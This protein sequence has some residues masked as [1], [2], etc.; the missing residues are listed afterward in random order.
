MPVSM[1]LRQDHHRVLCVSPVSIAQPEVAHALVVQLVLSHRQQ[2]QHLA[3]LVQQALT[4]QALD[5][6]VVPPVLQ[7]STLLRQEVR[8]AHHARPGHIAQRVQQRAQHARLDHIQQ[9]WTRRVVHLVPQEL[10]R[11]PVDRLHA[12]SV[13]QASTAQLEQQAV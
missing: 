4:H 11:L 12:A 2:A 13:R 3:R 1:H 10:T 6:R 5:H 8:F 7:V 9:V